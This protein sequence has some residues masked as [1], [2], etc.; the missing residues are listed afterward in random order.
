MSAPLGI[1]SP[2]WFFDQNRRVYQ[3]DERGHSFGAPIWREH[4][5]RLEIIGETPRSWC[6]G[7]PGG[8]HIVAKPPKSAFRDGA[9]PRDYA[10]SEEHI[11]RL[12][13]DLAALRARGE[14]SGPARKTD[15]EAAAEAKAS[16]GVQPPLP[17]GTRWACPRCGAE[18]VVEGEYSAAGFCQV[19]QKCLDRRARARDAGM[20]TDPELYER[21]GRDDAPPVLYPCA[22]R[23]H[24]GDH[25]AHGIRNEELARWPAAAPAP[26]RK[27]PGPRRRAREMVRAALASHRDGREARCADGV[28]IEVMISERELAQYGRRVRRAALLRQKRVIV[29]A[30]RRAPTKCLRCIGAAER[31]RFCKGFHAGVRVAAGVIEALARGG[32]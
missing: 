16:V 2:I 23:G 25:V 13:A 10:L 29:D 14:P 12:A 19:G 5:G 4:W 24:N 26:P 9:C 30:L 21:I 20:H 28:T 17:M 1:G 11:D 3:K 27:A 15:A 32:R 8:R 7:L 22:P 6:L 31:C 18:N